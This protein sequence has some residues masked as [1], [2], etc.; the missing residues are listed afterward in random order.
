MNSSPTLPENTALKRRAFLGSIGTLAAANAL[1]SPKALA[2]QPEEIA[3]QNL[4]RRLPKTR[5]GNAL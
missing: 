1:V 5:R 3:F 2:A 4:L